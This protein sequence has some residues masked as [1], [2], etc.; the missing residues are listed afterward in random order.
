MCSIKYLLWVIVLFKQAFAVSWDADAESACIIN[1]GSPTY[2]NPS[3]LN[4]Y[5]YQLL[6]NQ[7][8]RPRNIVFDTNGNVLV[9]GDSDGI[10]VLKTSEAAD[11]CVIYDGKTLLENSSGLKLNHGLAL[12][13]DGRTLFAS[14]PDV[15]YSWKYDPVKA[16]ID[17]SSRRKIVTGMDSGGHITRT[18][19][20]S[21]LHSD[22]LLVSRGSDG[23]L[24]MEAKDLSKGKC[25]I[26][27]F[28]VSK[29]KEQDFT[30]QGN[31][32]GWGLRNSVGLGEDS[33]GGIWAVENSADDLMREGIDIHQNNPAE[34]LN[35]LGDLGE[36]AFSEDFT[37]PNYGYP[38]C[39]AAWYPKDIKAAT[40][41]I[42]VGD[43]FALVMNNTFTDLTC[44]DMFQAPR[45]G[46]QAHMAPLDIKFH[47][48]TGHAWISFHGS[49]DRETPIGYMVSVVEFKGGEPKEPRNS[50]N[51]ITNI[52]WNSNIT[53]CPQ[54]CFRPVGIAFDRMGRTW[55]TSDSTGE[56]FIIT[57][58]HSSSSDLPPANRTWDISSNVSKKRSAAVSFAHSDVS[59]TRITVR[60]AITCILL[61]GVWGA[62]F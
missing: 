62:L 22:V 35:F 52:L 30:T 20:T 34:E 44:R 21:N 18:L 6:T 38:Y 2:P 32:L 59:L 12:S 4:G 15:V 3:V 56:I 8:T 26:K 49:W 17:N 5:T 19:L 7:L 24:D 31:L 14:S 41:D 45:L 16:T 60:V 58:P 13:K 50:N 61:L 33:Y 55:V 27:A 23:N 1:R 11:G 46:F 43:Q 25:M 51:S 29:T 57:P 28:S 42:K 48:Q 37:A 10:F 47:P 53:G 39:F 36:T 9:S 54:K 40:Y